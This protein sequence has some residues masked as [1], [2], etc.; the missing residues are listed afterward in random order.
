MKKNNINYVCN[1]KKED[2]VKA[3]I[4]EFEKV[5]KAL[6]DSEINNHSQNRK[7]INYGRYVA[8]IDLLQKVEIYEK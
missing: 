5:T 2:I 7:D 8:M 3:I 1:M 6:D 4:E